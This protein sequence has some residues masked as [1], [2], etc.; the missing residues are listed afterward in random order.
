ML[1][2]LTLIYG[3]GGTRW[4][5]SNNWWVGRG[6]GHSLARWGLSGQP[7][8]ESR[9]FPTSSL[10]QLWGLLWG[11]QTSV[12]FFFSNIL[13]A[14]VR[15]ATMEALWL[16]LDSKQPVSD[17]EIMFSTDQQSEFS[18]LKKYLTVP[19]WSC[20]KKVF[21]CLLAYRMD[22]KALSSVWGSMWRLGH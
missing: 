7:A 4:F 11:I 19:P 16:C 20:L 21:Q 3:K 6:V 13:Y 15:A 8:Y 22:S 1:L 14:H 18:R 10:P 2:K 9:T 17:P 5:P 12:M